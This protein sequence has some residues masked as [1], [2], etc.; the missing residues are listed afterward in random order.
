MDKSAKFISDRSG[1]KF[2]MSG[3]IMEPGTNIMIH[4]TETDGKY[5]A[6]QHPQANLN[7]YFPRFDDPKPLKDT[8]PDDNHAITQNTLDDNAV[9]DTDGNRIL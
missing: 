8:S 7:R 4:K 5:N 1:L 3:A 2:D 6:V 9:Y